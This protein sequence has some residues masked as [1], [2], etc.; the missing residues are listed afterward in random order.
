MSTLPTSVLCASQRYTVRLAESPNDLQLAQRLRFAVFNLELHEGLDNAYLTGLD[1]DAFDAVCDHL[2]VCESATEAVVGT[3]RLQT[4]KTAATGLGYYSAA[5]FNFSPYE[6][7][8]SSLV[9]L[10]RAC[11]AREHRSLS[12]LNLLWRGIALY[13]RQNQARYLIGCSSLS[14][15]DEAVGLGAWVHLRDRHLVEPRFRTEPLPAFAIDSA[16]NPV[17]EPL[18]RLLRAYLQAGAL[19]CGAPA[20]DREFRTIDFLTLMDLEN[21]QSRVQ[22][23]FLA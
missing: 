9:E 16:R 22:T 10:G 17:S 21:A 13:A 5:E 7:I 6:P 12:V 4:G 1:Q 11:V 20:I 19:V 8:R 18:P 15:Q 14:T 3:Y 23:H 2:L